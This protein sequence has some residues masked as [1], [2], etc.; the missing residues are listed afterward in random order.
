MKKVL[1]YLVVILFMHTSIICLQSCGSDVKGIDN[2]E[3]VVRSIKNGNTII[4]SNMLTVKLLGIENTPSSFDY[5][6][7]EL[8]GKTIRLKADKTLPAA[9]S[10]YVD[11]SKDSVFAHVA[12]VNSA[13]TSIPINGYMLKSGF[14]KWAATPNNDSATVYKN[15]S[16]LIPNVKLT[17]E[18]LCL[19]MTPATFLIEDKTGAIGTGFFISDD[20]LA[21]TNNH[22]INDEENAKNRYT[23]YLS[24]E[25][26]NIS[27]DKNRPILRVLYT[28]A[29][30]D[31]TIFRV[32][33]D[34]NEKSPCLFV[35][36]NVPVRGSHV[37]VV[38]NP[39][40]LTATFSTGEFSAFRELNGEPHTIQITAPVN[41]GNS[42]GPICDEYGIVI[43]IVKSILA[44][45]AGNADTGNL[46]FG[47][48]IRVP[49]LVLNKLD[50]VKTYYGK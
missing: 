49:R 28:N 38:G 32:R 45:G 4:L 2:Q 36:R 12:L 46:N 43:G 17:D 44:D 22:V 23:I 24:D 6:K 29:D 10:T 47:V 13:S 41:H 19:K 7:Q 20:G 42:G 9:Y 1:C 8:V 16:N 48:D 34:P 21:L 27:K 11:A 37:G 18:Q 39:R 40:G 3:F 15:Y 14:A 35:A 50:D 25:Y 33:L 26:G 30:Y 31:F 5:L